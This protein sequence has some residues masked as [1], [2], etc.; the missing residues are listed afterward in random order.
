MWSR[1]KTSACTLLNIKLFLCTNYLKCVPILYKFYCKVVTVCIISEEEVYSD[2]DATL[3]KMYFYKVNTFLHK[4][5]YRRITL[6]S[7]FKSAI[8]LLHNCKSITIVEH[9]QSWSIIH[10]FKFGRKLPTNSFGQILKFVTWKRQ[11][12]LHVI[13]RRKVFSAV[14]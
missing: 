9:P 13:P 4:Y 10:P 2:K 14:G 5:Y 11:N 7:K 6:L 8:K 3:L 12:Y 1:V